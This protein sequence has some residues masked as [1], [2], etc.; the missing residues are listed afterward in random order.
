MSTERLLWISLGIYLLG[1]QV[2]Q[3]LASLGATIFTLIF[4]GALARV[5]YRKRLDEFTS[6]EKMAFLSA[7]LYT[8]YLVVGLLFFRRWNTNFWDAISSAPLW[9]VAFPAILLKERLDSR[10]EDFFIRFFSLASLAN[11][12]FSLYQIFVLDYRF[13]VA[14]MKSPIYLAYAMLPFLVFWFERLRMEYDLRDLFR[15]KKWELVGWVCST[16]VLFLTASRT[17]CAVAL[18]YLAIRGLPWA[19]RWGRP[20]ILIF[21]MALGVAMAAALVTFHPGV[22]AKVDEMRNIRTN[23]SWLSRRDIWNHNRKLFFGDP[24]FGVGYKQNGISGDQSPA[25]W[26]QY[27][28]RGPQLYYA[29]SIYLQAAAE[30]GIL[31]IVLLALSL[32]GLALAFPTTIPVILVTLAAGVTENTFSNSKPLNALLGI[33]LFLVFLSRKKKRNA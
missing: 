32:I 10:K 20:R 6:W 19:Y 26:N 16:I 15:S 9:V 7:A 33:L 22:R 2:S 13:A 4:W 3:S 14:W 5:I 30:S 28:I 27:N 12:I 25:D 24:I 8:V 1:I 11:A 31:G 18:V 17:A 29:H 23:D 21:V